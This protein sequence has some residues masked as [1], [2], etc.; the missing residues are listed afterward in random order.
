[1]RATI[2]SVDVVGEAEH[3]LGVGV[4]V[5][6]RDLHGDAIALG[7]HVNRLVVQDVLAAVQM[8]DELGD[9]AVVLELG[10]LR[11]ARLLVRGALVGQRDQQA[12]VEERHLAQ[13]LRQGVV[14]VF[15]DGE[16]FLVGKE[17]NLGAALLGGAGLLQ[18]RWWARPWSSSAPRRNRR[19]RSRVRAGG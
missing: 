14:V 7:F 3:G 17:V 8:L 10:L 12:L 15:G 1:M 2:D 16:D 11:F 18:L 19:A 6:Q 4:V 5:L 13:A 9:T